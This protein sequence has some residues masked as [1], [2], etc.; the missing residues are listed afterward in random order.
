MTLV[1]RPD[2]GEEMEAQA[3]ARQ[4]IEELLDSTVR[5]NVVIRGSTATRTAVRLA[6]L[7]EAKDAWESVDVTNEGWKL[8]LR[9]KST[10]LLAEK[11]EKAA[12]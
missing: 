12:K 2:T 4:Q 3:F 11:K 1:R 9:N 5:R 8:T 10:I 6:L 7:A